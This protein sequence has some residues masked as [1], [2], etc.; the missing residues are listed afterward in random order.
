MT[1][2]SFKQAITI[3]PILLL[4][5]ISCKPSQALSDFTQALIDTYA[6]NFDSVRCDSEGVLAAID[7]S[8][9]VFCSTVRGLLE[10]FQEEGRD[11]DAAHLQFILD[12]IS[13]TEYDCSRRDSYNRGAGNTISCI[14]LEDFAELA[15]LDDPQGFDLSTAGPLLQQFRG[16]IRALEGG[17]PS[18]SLGCREGPVV[19]RFAN[20][21]I[22]SGTELFQNRPNPT[23][24]LERIQS[25]VQASCFVMTTQLLEANQEIIRAFT[26]IENARNERIVQIDET[27]TSIFLD[28]VSSAEIDADRVARYRSACQANDGFYEQIEFVATCTETDR[29]N[30]VVSVDRLTVNDFPRCYSMDCTSAGQSVNQLF[31]TNL[32]EEYTLRATERMNEERTGNSWACTGFTGFGLGED[33]EDEVAGDGGTSSGSNSDGSPFDT[34]LCELENVALERTTE[35]FMVSTT[36]SGNFFTRL[37]SSNFRVDLENAA[38]FEASCEMEEGVFKNATDLSIICTQVRS[39][40]S[41][42]QA[43]RTFALENFPVCLGASCADTFSAVDLLEQTLRDSEII[44][45]SDEFVWTCSGAWTKESQGTIL[46]V[47]VTTLVLSLLSVI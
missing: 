26:A 46:L 7:G 5:F 19:A 33:I 39:S 20:L 15:L 17:N 38:D 29:N 34:T 22:S 1:T 25:A 44:R 23:C 42:E 43:T 41:R 16:P 6:E 3:T 28:Y 30:N 8:S 40:T 37:F 21:D 31:A 12:R 32:F 36:E 4:L 18:S 24:A 13:P 47:S 9:S 45:D 27:I 14:P 11:I 2:I 10:T 35:Q